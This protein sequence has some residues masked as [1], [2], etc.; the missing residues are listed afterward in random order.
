MREIDARPAPATIAALSVM[1]GLVVLLA[2]RFGTGGVVVVA[3]LAVI[4]GCLRYGMS[5]IGLH[6]RSPT[7]AATLRRM[8][9]T[10]ALA[11]R[12][13]AGALLL[14]VAITL[15]VLAQLRMTEPTL[16]ASTI[17]AMAVGLALFATIAPLPAV[18][19]AISVQAWR[20][21]REHPARLWPLAGAG[22]CGWFVWTAMRQRQ[23]DDP[24]VDIV[25]LWLLSLGLAIAAASPA[26]ARTAWP[27]AFLTW[28]RRRWLD[29]ASVCGLMLAALVARSVALDR[30]PDIFDA[31]EAAMAMSAVEILGGNRAH[32]F[33][34]G[35]LGHPN[36][37]FYLQAGSI[38]LFG[39]SVSGVRMLSAL[40]GT[41]AV[42]FTWL[43]ARRLFNRR[44]AFV[45]AAILAVFHFHLYF[46]RLSLNNVA[47]TFF[48]VMT[49]YLLN[50]GFSERRRLD[51]LLAGM[52][53][54]ISQYF[55]MGARLIPIVAAVVVLS[56]GTVILL[57]RSHGGFADLPRW[58]R[59]VGWMLGGAVLSYL[60]LLAHYITH[61]ETFAA[62]IQVVSIFA[63]GWLAQEQQTTGQSATVLI[64]RNVWR[65]AL[66]PFHLAPV[67][68]YRGERPF[69]GLPMAIPIGLGLALITVRAWQ[70]RF[71]A[72]AVSYW[73]ATLS[74]GLT[75]SPD[76]NRFV[77]AAPIY[78]I[79]CG[80]ALDALARIAADLLR[81]HRWFVQGALA[82]T[83][84]LL[85]GWNLRYFFG[86]HEQLA[87]YSDP[88]TLLASE[89]ARHL[90]TVE[91]GTLVYFAGPPRMWYDGFPNLAF[92]ARDA[93]GISVEQPWD[94]SMPAPR[95]EGPTVFV[96]VPERL[97]EAD[98]VRRWFP[99]GTTR[100]FRFDSGNLLF[101]VYEVD[102]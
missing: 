27:S 38:R 41:L 64:A 75:V 87:L 79:A 98:Q 33:G 32:P 23:G 68:M 54:G 12:R 20:G 14:I 17:A 97:S 73:G 92:I 67:G 4:G 43:L 9:V 70:H 102:P 46:S 81:L 11:K 90:E 76:T 93:R 47:D 86:E 62:R 30:Y 44:T 8:S 100:H 89:L 19:P 66:V 7:R 24:Y 85:V 13:S 99:E 80:L 94:A 31:D 1:L 57:R 60:P 28:T 34:T 51:C 21:H 58:T 53:I 96:F 35:W 26:V 74:I 45:A 63:S 82:V 25:V 56:Y 37:F 65:A 18:A 72:L 101:S 22:V 78:A 91:P 6:W 59:L 61:P 36:L 40:L 15:V 52:S 16:S 39:D 84:A 77:I 71:F 10:S 69:V 3:T 42:L 95:I 5:E 55:Y 29:L 49:L 2:L 50:R 88:N 48:L 83:V